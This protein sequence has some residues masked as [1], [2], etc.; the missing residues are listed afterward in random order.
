MMKVLQCKTGGNRARVLWI[1]LPV[2]VILLLC[3]YLLV[4]L[5][6]SAV[7]ERKQAALLDGIE[8]RNQARILR[9]VSREY[10]DRWQFQR[11]EI[12]ESLV[13]VGRQFLTLMLSREGE[14]WEREG[15]TATLSVHWKIDGKALG[16][17]AQEAM[18]ILNR[19]ESPF[20][21]TWKK[22]SFLPSSWKLIQVEQK[23]LP[24]DL[25]GYRPGDIG[26]AMKG[27]M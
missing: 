19:I 18:R 22:E 26:R 27:E 24:D 20:E 6:S 1:V 25:Y 16:P 14:H 13:D 15:D 21:F 23:E 3:V 4:V 5:R 9:L 7:L 12:A 17:G 11:E 10:T 2:V 8:R